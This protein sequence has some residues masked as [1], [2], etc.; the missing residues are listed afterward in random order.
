MSF[1]NGANQIKL[2]EVDVKDVTSWDNMG[3]QF[4]LVLNIICELLLGFRNT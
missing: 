4:L 1:G 3:F 2:M